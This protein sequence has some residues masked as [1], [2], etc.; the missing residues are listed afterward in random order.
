[1]T[2]DVRDPGPGQP[3]SPPHTRQAISA[4]SSTAQPAPSC[5]TSS[6]STRRN[7]TTCSP[8]TCA[9]RS[10]GSVPSARTCAIAAPAHRQHRIRLRVSRPRRHRS[11]LRDLEG[12]AHRAHPPG[13]CGARP[14]GRHG[15]R[16]RARHDRRRDRP[17]AGRRPDRRA[18]S[19]DPGGTARAAGGDRGP[20]RLAPLRRRGLR[21]RG[22]RSWPMAAPR[23]NNLRRQGAA[24]PPSPLQHPRSP[25]PQARRS[26]P[27]A[28]HQSPRRQP[29]SGGRGRRGVAP[30]PP[31][32]LGRR[33]QVLVGGARW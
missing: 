32:P 15:Q 9:A 31:F 24:V 3:P 4:P 23:S 14:R 22:R 1:M 20:H 12:G 13:G 27:A 2:M 6:R 26:T 33:E 10:S 5:E 21:E 8:P 16:G 25:G 19:R 18:G 30:L 11:P 7:G 29:A 17:R 28:V